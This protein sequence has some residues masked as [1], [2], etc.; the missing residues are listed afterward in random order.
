MAKRKKYRAR[1][2]FKAIKGFRRKH[3]GTAGLMAT[4]VG[5]AAYGA[6]REK[7]STALQ[8]IT[9][10]VPLG[11]ISDE[12]VLGALAVMLKKSRIGKGMLSPVLNGAITIESARIGEAIIQGQVGIGG[13]TTANTNLLG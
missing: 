3:S 1:K 10:K 13:T 6:M 9:S 5:A 11:N 12:I 4:V 2:S 8:P 7:I